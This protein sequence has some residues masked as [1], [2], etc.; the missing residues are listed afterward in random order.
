MS[1]AVD[2]KQ[3]GKTRIMD[4]ELAELLGVLFVLILTSVY[5]G[6]V[7][8]VLWNWFVVPLGVTAIGI[9]HGVGIYMVTGL[10]VSRGRTRPGPIKW[11]DAF[12]LPLMA[13]AT[14][15]AAKQFM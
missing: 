1:N 12:V 2:E 10:L 14:G 7:L 3:A 8:S 9:A 15:Y 13:L 11:L 4:S 5:Y 6:W